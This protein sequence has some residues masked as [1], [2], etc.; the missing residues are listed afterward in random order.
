ML[1][2]ILIQQILIEVVVVICKEIIKRILFESDYI[3]VETVFVIKK[4]H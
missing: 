1:I 3:N 4:E 2:H